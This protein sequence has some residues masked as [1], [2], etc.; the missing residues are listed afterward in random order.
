MVF[1]VIMN[2]NFVM[3]FIILIFLIHILPEIKKKYN[4]KRRIESIRVCIEKKKNERR[5]KG[6]NKGTKFI[7][8]VCVNTYTRI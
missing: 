2:Q 6:N 7:V 1:R 5:S 8:C 4:F 3:I